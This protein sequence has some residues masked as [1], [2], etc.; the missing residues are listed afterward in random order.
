LLF[1]A[2]ALA[3]A[4]AKVPPLQSPAPAPADPELQ[5]LVEKLTELS[6]YIGKNSQSS[7]VWRYQLAQGEVL[8]QLAARTRGEERDNWLRMAVDSEYS[9]S[10]QS[11]DSETTAPQRLVQLS[12]QLAQSLPGNPVAVYAARQEIQ[13]E[14]TRMLGRTDNP[15]KAQQ[16]LCDR[17]FRFA[18]QYPSSTE[19]PAAVQEAARLSETLGKI[20]QA[21]QCYRYLAQHFPNLTLGRK[22]NGALWRLGQGS[23]P[24]QVRLPL[25]FPFGPREE[26]FTLEEFRGRLVIVYFWSSDSP[27][28]A[29]DMQRLKQLSDRYQYRGLGIVYVN[30]DNDPAKARAFLSGRLTAGVHLHQRGGL[31]SAV[32]ERYG[33][34]ALPHVFLLARDGSLLQ[35][36]QQTTG[37]ALAVTGHM[38]QRR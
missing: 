34:Q 7:Q 32:A 5:R 36:M 12:A 17:L 38:T 6:E 19:A 35:H 13:A 24:V 25:L 20:D 11:P 16:H 21:R 2:G 18:Q 37:L 14:Y 8:L 30:L 27:R 22:A 33:L 26:P 23:E 1:A 29:E 31:D 28:V 15:D 10:V 9:A 3:D 4:T